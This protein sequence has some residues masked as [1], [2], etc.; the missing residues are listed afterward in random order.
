MKNAVPAKLWITRAVALST[1]VMMALV[2]AV[3]L[4]AKSEPVLVTNRTTAT[5][6]TATARTSSH[7]SKL[8]PLDTVSF[9]LPDV[10]TVTAARTGIQR[11]TVPAAVSV[12][13]ATT[14]ETARGY[15][16][17]EVLS[18]VPGALVQ[19]RNGNQDVRIS[20]RGFGARGAGER[21]NAATTR[22]IRFLLNG[23]PLT[24]PDGRTSL[25][26]VDPWSVSSVEVVRSNTS[27]LWGNASGGIVSIS[28]LPTTPGSQLKASTA[29]GSFGFMKNS[30]AYTAVQGTTRAYAGTS[31]TTFDGWREHSGSSMFQLMAGVETLIGSKTLLG[32]HA[33]GASNLFRIPGPLTQTQFDADARQAQAD[34][35]VYNP[36]YVARDERRFNRIGRIGVSIDHELRSGHALSFTLFTEP[37]FIQRSERNTFRDFTRYHVG[38]SAT[39]S[40]DA[41]ITASVQSKL[42]LGM[43]N[44]FQDGA[45][46][47]YS[48]D[49]VTKARG[50]V[51]RDNKSEA[52]HS[53][54]VFAQ[55]LI[56]V[57]DDLHVLAGL[58]S[59]NITYSYANFIN[60]KLNE[61]R[62]F[63][64]LSPKIG[65]NYMLGSE[66]S[67]YGNLAY[68]IE[69]PAGNET[70]PP[71]AFG[72]DTLRPINSL[73]EPI[74][75][76]TIEAG[77]KIALSSGSSVVRSAAAD[78]AV[79]MVTTEN[80][81][82]PYRGGRFYMSAG[83][84][85]RVG[86]E[87][88]SSVALMGGISAMFSASVSSNTLTNYTFD[89]SF[90]NASLAGRQLDLSGNIMPGVPSL[91][92]TVR[93][94][95]EP[96]YIRG[97]KVEWE[98]RYVGMMYAND[99]NTTSAPAYT[100]TD[101][102]ASYGFSVTNGVRV[103]A[104]AR[105]NNLLDAR[106]VAGVWLNPDLTITTKQPV[107][108]D[109]GLP[110]NWLSGVNVEYAL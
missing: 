33:A 31:N 62:T 8:L 83:S 3:S 34:S 102:W 104:F 61:S 51:L 13:P 24:E 93:L 97:F 103:R 68:G 47:F 81:L 29:L 92:A 21:S 64:Q 72:E 109:P 37:K 90:V 96:A 35:T 28:T 85:R 100:T 67:V 89:S 6:A 52:A 22:G 42:L 48:L 105:M 78:L 18:V 46:L 32:V 53:M 54:G 19:S 25:D 88:G 1:A 108:I 70:D 14:F 27:A 76:R 2:T 30:L 16:L 58:R 5:T 55:E 94:A 43:D 38:G 40:Y 107:F 23:M 91:F 49:P 44:T 15:G 41:A 95:Y 69:I 79:Y 60:P 84:T 56:T 71:A 98:T 36:T 66:W 73:L 77:T 65:V 59:D 26:L 80:D 4:Q 57:A 17:D 39:Y 82:I 63:S 11:L 86:V 75:S 20:I 87:L 101:V 99:V 106:Y 12:I 9:I 7:H 10:V 50:P 45:I 110:R 74:R